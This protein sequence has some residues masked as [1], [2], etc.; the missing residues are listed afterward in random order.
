[1]ARIIQFPLKSTPVK[2]GLQPVGK[3]RS[4]T[5]TKQT[6]QLDLFT[7]G[8][9]VRLNQLSAFEEALLLDE[10]GEKSAAKSGYQNAIKKEECVADA[11]CNLGILEFQEGDQAKAIDCFTNALKYQPRHHEAH[12][13]LAN[14][15]AEAGNLPLAKMHYQVAIEIAPDFSNSYFNLALAHAM[16]REYKEAMKAL[17]TFKELTPGEDH[18]PTDNLMS[19][20]EAMV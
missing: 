10:R 12:Y 17:I 2:L 18:Q 13:N 3:R 14:L 11:Y 20:L 6:S 15:Y 7:G 19:Q 9:V 8:K 16:L 4:R 5:S 1:M